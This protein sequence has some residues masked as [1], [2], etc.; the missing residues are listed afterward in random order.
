[1]NLNIC[2]WTTTRKR[3]IYI[4]SWINILYT[5]S[6]Q[7]QSLPWQEAYRIALKP[8]K[9]CWNTV[10]TGSRCQRLPEWNLVITEIF[11]WQIFPADYF[12]PCLFPLPPCHFPI[13]IPWCFSSTKHKRSDPSS[14]AK[15]Q[16]R[17]SSLP[18][19]ALFILSFSAAN[20]SRLFSVSF[21][22]LSS[23]LFYQ[24][25]LLTW[26]ENLKIESHWSICWMPPLVKL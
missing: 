1:M 12:F 5:Q 11:L 8:S 17:L 2:S 13:H 9:S 21:L 7:N 19:G 20:F 6:I 3:L 18:F 10:S 25:L 15:L 22:W 16:Q 26:K 24:S 14:R 4:V 23:A